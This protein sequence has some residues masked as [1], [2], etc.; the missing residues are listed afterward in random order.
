MDVMCITCRRRS[1]RSYTY[2]LQASL[3]AAVAVRPA[4]VGL[5]VD[6]AARPSA[7]ENDSRA[8]QVVVDA[9]HHRM[10]AL[11]LQCV[12]ISPAVSELQKSD[13][14]ATT[15]ENEAGENAL[16]LAPLLS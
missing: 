3:Q 15:N 10:L 9:K 11:R 6:E 8:I 4:R 2:A 13:Q 14:K 5:A 7:P 16:Y 1:L 12:Q